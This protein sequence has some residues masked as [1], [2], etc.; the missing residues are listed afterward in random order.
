MVQDRQDNQNLRRGGLLLF[1]VVFALAFSLYLAT[2]APGVTFEDSGE[3]ASAAYSLGIAHPPGYPLFSLLGHLFSE[4]PTNNVAWNL[5]LLSAFLTALSLAL[6]SVLLWKLKGDF[7]GAGLVVLLVLG[8]RTIWSTATVTEVY[9]LNLLFFVLVNLVLFR[10][11]WDVERKPRLLGLTAFLLGL[12]LANHQSLLLALPG[13]LCA[14]TLSGKWKTI[15]LKD[16]LGSG[17]LFLLG[18]L[19]YLYLPIRASAHPPMNWGNPSQWDS[20]LD[21]LFRRQYGGV[22]F[23]PSMIWQNVKQLATV[24]PLYELVGIRD[25]SDGGPVWLHLSLLPL[26]WFVTVLGFVRSPFRVFK[27]TA[28]SHS[29]FFTVGIILI[30]QTPADK[31]F[32]LKVFYIPFWLFFSLYFVEGILSLFKGVKSRR[33]GMLLVLLV[34][35]A[36]LIFNLRNSQNRDYTY[37]MDYVDA[38]FVS[39]PQDAI[40]ITKKDNETFNLWYAQMVERKRS[41]LWIVN[42]IT[43]SEHWYVRQLERTYPGLKISLQPGPSWTREQIRDAV[44]AEIV[45]KYSSTRNILFANKE[46]PLSTGKSLIP[47]GVLYRLVDS[48]EKELK[49]YWIGMSK[50]RNLEGKKWFDVMTMLMLQNLSFVAQDA[51]ILHFNLNQ[52]SEAERAFQDSIFLN[53][54]IGLPPNNFLA[55]KYLGLIKSKTGNPV[56]AMGFWEKAV[57]TQPGSPASKLLAEELSRMRQGSS[58]LLKAE[59]LYQAGRFTD[60]IPL[61]KAEFSKNP[62]AKI[63]ANVGDCHFNLKQYAEAV[64]WYERALSIDRGYLTAYYN[65]GGSYL[66]LNQVAK[67][68]AIWTAGLKIDPNHQGM[69]SAMKQ[70]LGK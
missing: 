59:E 40:I 8:M 46:M 5:N 67:A 60:A 24:N 3:L 45:E 63:A 56:E 20:F 51:G 29:L 21:V 58:L 42:Y 55:Y 4:F 57:E 19:V 50:F 23:D 2:L 28:F 6:F 33:L 69:K 52:W 34:I 37:S 26:V 49:P 13:I 43:L 9:A 27:W 32:T 16:L 36:T 41:D 35:A 39:A 1:L 7:L 62:S 15:T 11:I 18:L 31:E 66:M 10:F 30:S 12:G 22:G 38:V 65:L 68:E 48:G 14:I 54:M 47:S 53:M 61:Y 25:I 17:V 64:R 70:Y 44:L